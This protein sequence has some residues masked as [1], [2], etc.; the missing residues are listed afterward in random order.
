MKHSKTKEMS[1]GLNICDIA[2]FIAY[3]IATQNLWQ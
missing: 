2:Q 3:K 1:L